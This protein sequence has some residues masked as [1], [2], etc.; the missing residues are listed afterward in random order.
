MSV[1]TFWHGSKTVIEDFSEAAATKGVHFG[2]KDQA[3]MRN[4]AF[5]HEVEVDLDKT[6]RS[7]DRQS[8]SDVASRARRAGCDAVRYLNRY[9][10]MPIDRLNALLSAGHGDSLDTISDRAFRKLVPESE[11]SILVV[12]PSA[13]R[14]LRIFDQEGNVVLDCHSAPTPEM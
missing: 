3:S 7:R 6:S 1:E 9:E 11:D 13:I 4:A 2:T 14:L 10:G 5:L 8:W 12:N